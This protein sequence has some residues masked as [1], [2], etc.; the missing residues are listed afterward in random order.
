MRQPRLSPLAPRSLP[1]LHRLW[2]VLPA[3]Q[4]RRLLLHGATALA[5]KPGPPPSSSTGV[6]VVGE[7]SRASGLGES[8]RWTLRGLQG[9]GVKCTA[10]D[11]GPLLPG[12]RAD[13]PSPGCDVPP[14]G[15]ALALHVN[16]PS[17]PLALL[18]LPRGL[19]RGRHVI[20][21]WSWELPTASPAWRVGPGF[22]REVW[23][24]SAFTADA[25]APLVPRPVRVVPYALALEPERVPPQRAR[26]GIAEGVVAVL[27]SAN[28]ASSFAR[29]NPLA[30]VEAFRSAFGERADRLLILKTGNPDHF[31]AESAP[32]MEAV[33]SAGNIRLMTETLPEADSRALTASADIVLSLHRSEGFGLVVAEAMMQ[34]RAVIAT[35]WSANMEFMDA[36][37]AVPVPYRLVPVSDPRGVYD[38]PGAQWA[39]PDVGAAAAALRQLA[40]DADARA[41]LGARAR[42]AVLRLGTDPLADAVRGLGIAV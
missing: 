7:F 18:R 32:L 15:Y 28:L 25:V 24:P 1:L 20:G 6:A 37:C 14:P 26:F 19:L 23:A 35:G 9:L 2:R 34:A 33:R 16:P 38:A 30:A 22:V 11:V 17:L 13:L 4:R 29:K 3:D 8:A 21:F 36:D 31:P 42:A 39:E 40:D 5:P 10:M 27:V 41:A 12:H